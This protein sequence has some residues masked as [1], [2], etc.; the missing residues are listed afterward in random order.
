[1]RELG[2]VEG[3]NV[4]VERRGAA[5]DL[6]R[7]PIV[8]AEL[9]KLKVDVMTIWGGGV[10]TRAREADRTVPICVRAAD[11]QAEGLVANLA[12]PEGNVT[13]V[14]TIQADLAGKR[15]EI[16]REAV[17]GLARV[18]VLIADTTTTRI[19]IIRNA[20]DAA[21]AMG[22]QLYVPEVN[23]PPDDFI[24]AFSTLTK[25]GVR[26]LSIVNSP[27]L[28]LHYK[29]LAALAAKDHIATIGDFQEWPQVGGLIAYGPLVS[30]IS[31]QWAECVDKI[32]RGAKPAQVP[33]Q[34][35][36]KFSL[37]I[38]LKTAKALGLTIPD[39]LLRRADEVIQ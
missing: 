28:N 29:Q 31:R 25:N 39:S 23:R 37:V 5:G 35:P 30:E 21:R 9:V 13:G 17:P 33:V 16:L 2:W 22:L 24:Q 34:Q 15:L 3:Q 20:E 4:V 26:G 12:K 38:N 14:Q 32:L 36:T 18:G 8:A 19:R 11:L 27:R 1:M 10:A 6:D 7:L